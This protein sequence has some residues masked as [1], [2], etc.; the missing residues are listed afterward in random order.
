[1]GDR[2]FG[3]NRLDLLERLFRRRLRRRPVLHDLGPGDLP[4]MRV[5]DL[6]LGRVERPK[7]RYGWAEDALSDI[8]HPVRIFGV[9]P[10]RVALY[11]HWH[12]W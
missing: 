8:G 5:L 12:R 7:G 11:D 10:P 4:N 3:E 1:M 9:E 6:G 2:V